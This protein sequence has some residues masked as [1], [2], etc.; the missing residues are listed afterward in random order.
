M[1]TARLAVNPIAYWL[2]GGAPDRTV[3]TLGAAFTELVA[4]GYTAV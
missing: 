4:I 3:R 2:A 1:T